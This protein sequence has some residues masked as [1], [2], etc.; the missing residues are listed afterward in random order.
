MLI[1]KK[2][3][4]SLAV[5]M[6]AL[7]GCG[8]NGGTSGTGGGPGGTGGAGATGGAGGNGGN[9]ISA[10]F[11]AFCMRRAECSY[12]P[13]EDCI[14]YFTEVILPSSNLDPDCQALVTYF[15]CG[16]RLTCEEILVFETGCENEY[17]AAIG[18]CVLTM[19]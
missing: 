15:E 18:T 12:Y 5:S 3:I 9:G 7:T 19:P 13:F 14:T 8:G 10:A 17:N 11:E 6:L 1:P 16:S 2:T 4:P